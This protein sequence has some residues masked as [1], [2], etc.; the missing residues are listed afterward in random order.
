MKKFFLLFVFF[1]FCSNIFLN[2]AISKKVSVFMEKANNQ[3]DSRFAHLLKMCNMLI[4]RL[5]PPPHTHIY[6]LFL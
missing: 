2:F 3:Y 4:I 5:L 1:L 6:R